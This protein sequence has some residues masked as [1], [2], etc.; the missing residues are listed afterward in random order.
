[1][2]RPTRA[3]L[4]GTPAVILCCLIASLLLAIAPA[5]AAAGVHYTKESLQT[6]EQQ[7]S[8]GQIAS[9]IINKRVGSVRV[10][11]KDG[12]HVLAHYLS[13]EEPKVAAALEAKGVPFTVLRPSEAVKEASKTPVKHK[14]RYIAGGILVL[15]VIVVGIV[16]LVDR[17]R[18]AAAE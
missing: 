8:G 16:L 10:T 11:L 15:V 12:S 6:Y 7:L 13:H 4:A 17:R 9:V 3:P 14:L 1:M 18:K 2:I 5:G